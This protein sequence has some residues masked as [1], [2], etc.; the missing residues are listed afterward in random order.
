MH[1]MPLISVINREDIEE[2]AIRIINDEQA[3]A[4]IKFKFCSVCQ[5]G[6]ER[7]EVG[8]CQCPEGVSGSCCDLVNG[9]LP[10]IPSLV[11]IPNK[12]FSNNMAAR[13]TIHS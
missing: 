2:S 6:G 13:P 10:E 8:K 5:N 4:Y 1:V 3:E 9:R 7:S 12:L 11:H